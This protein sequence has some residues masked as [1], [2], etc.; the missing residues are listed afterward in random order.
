MRFFLCFVALL[1]VPNALLAEVDSPIEK[2][3]FARG[4]ALAVE[5]DGAFFSIE[6][7]DDLYKTVRSG[8]YKDV[9]VFDSLGNRVAHSID[10]N[11]G[12]A[13]PGIQKEIPFFPL[14]S[15]TNGEDI[16]DLAMKVVRDEKG[17][18]ITVDASAGMLS[19]GKNSA[20]ATYLLDLSE[21]EQKIESLEFFW[22][23]EKLSDSLIHRVNIKQ[24][25]DLER[26]STL[27]MGAALA[28]LR[29]GD[30]RVIKRFVKLGKGVKKYLKLTWS[31]KSGLNLVKVVGHSGEVVSVTDR[32]WA[33]LGEGVKSVEDGNNS[34]IFTSP[35]H[36][37]VSNLQIDFKEKNSLA[38]LIVESRK[39]ENGRWTKRCRGLFYKLSVDTESFTNE[40]CSFST[41][42]DK[43][44]RVRFVSGSESDLQ[45][46]E[47]MQLSLGWLPVEL[48]FI[49]QG[50]KPYLLAYG[51][52]R[53]AAMDQA[54]AIPGIKQVI[55]DNSFEKIQGKVVL[56]E[57][58]ILGGE[59]ALLPPE[60]PLAWKKWIL[61]GVLIAGV[62]FLGYMVRSLLLDMRKEG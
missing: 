40:L 37:Q 30:Q 10:E 6:L 33:Q 46:M 23:Q 41:T 28:D 45:N 11:I 48:H 24:S 29:F 32:Q 3:D 55:P 52:G 49:A 34:L 9:A 39:D 16:S 31:D 8:S 62:G 57:P 15:P 51:S 22:A 7:P 18:I 19:S 21:V 20:I 38:G 56:K 61:W 17:T 25:N 50:K 43:Q 59:K 5:K 36:L 14:H 47:S 60:E 26:W 44:W 58:V 42:G 27:V 53:V 12:K 4:Y 54:N 35:Y 13:M 2:E 1:L